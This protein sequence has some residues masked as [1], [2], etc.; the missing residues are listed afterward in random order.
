MTG[1]R[2]QASPGLLVSLRRLGATTLEIA[3]IRL[4]LLETE[5]ERQKLAIYSA[6]LWG[7]IGIACVAVGIV[8]LSALIVV[9]FWDSYRLFAIAG[10]M[11]ANFVAGVLILRYAVNRLQTPSG[12]FAASRAELMR[13]QAALAPRDA[14]AAPQA[15]AAPQ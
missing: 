13:D 4:E 5:V 6:L 14:A 11:L 1:P 8:L 2:A 15:G 9:L 3:R 12:A 10:L 7:L